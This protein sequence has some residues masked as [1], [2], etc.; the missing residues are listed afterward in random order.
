MEPGREGGEEDDGRRD[1]G[2]ADLGLGHD[3]GQ[4]QDPPEGEEGQGD[5]G[6]ARTPRR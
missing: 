2:P 3:A 5:Q 6:Q 4:E 1:G